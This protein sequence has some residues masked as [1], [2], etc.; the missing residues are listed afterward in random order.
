[1]TWTLQCHKMATHKSGFPQALEIM[2]NLEY[3]KKKIPCM[4][5]SWNLKK[6]ELSWKNHGILWNNNLCVRQLVCWLPAASSFNYFKMHAWST[7][8]LLLLHSA[9]MLSVE[10]MLLKWEAWGCEFNFSWKLH[11]WSW[12]VMEKSWNC[13]FEFLWEPWQVISQ[14]KWYTIVPQSFTYF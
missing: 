2:E 14:T 4:E 13:V 11:R 5:K 6:P 8:M 3:H 1:M 9:F 7:C 10:K 12:K